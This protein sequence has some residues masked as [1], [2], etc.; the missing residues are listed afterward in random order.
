MKKEV[1][2]KPK[3][4]YPFLLLVV[5][6][7]AGAVFAIIQAQILAALALFLFFLLVL[8]GFYIVYPNHSKAMV[9]FGAYKGTVKENGFFGSIHFL[10]T[11][12]F[13]CAPAISTV[14]V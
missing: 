2:L 3:S 14:S 9:L 7:L 12:L 4:G 8:K 10:A 5:L 1:L 13:H 11:G 6:I